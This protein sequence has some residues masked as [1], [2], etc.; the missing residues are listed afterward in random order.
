MSL[1]NIPEHV[2]PGRK[3]HATLVDC[4]SAI[5]DADTLTDPVDVLAHVPPSESIGI[6]CAGNAAAKTAAITPIT[7]LN[8]N[9]RFPRVVARWP[10]PSRIPDQN[11]DI[12]PSFIGDACMSRARSPTRVPERDTVRVSLASRTEAGLMQR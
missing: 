1:T 3:L 11:R 10:V 8:A 9:V 7:R 2:T 4:P 6:A 5:E 12:L